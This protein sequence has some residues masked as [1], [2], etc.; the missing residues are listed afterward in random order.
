M[1]YSPRVQPQVNES[2]IHKVSKNNRFIFHLGMV[3]EL[4]YKTMVHNS[5]HVFNLSNSSVVF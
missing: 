5:Q 2:L 3:S 1:I 4:W